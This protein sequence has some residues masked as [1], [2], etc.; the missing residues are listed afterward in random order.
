MSPSRRAVPLSAAA[1]LVL[2]L[3][4]GLLQIGRADAAPVSAAAGRLA[5][6]AGD[7][8]A[9]DGHAYGLTD[10]TGRTMDAAEIR[11]AADG[12]Y[13]AVYHTV[14][15]DGRFHAAVA[16]STDLVHWT[17]RHDFGPGTHQATLAED[18]AGGWI[19]A[20]ER[21]PR[22]HIAIRGYASLDGLLSGQADRSFDAPLTLSRCAEGTPAITAVRGDTIE[23]TGH[24]RS[25]CD[26][27]RQLRATLEDFT[28]WQAEPDPTL[29]TALRAWGSNGNIGDRSSVRLD[30][31]DLVVI[32]G[33]RLRD[34]FASWRTYIYD[35]RRGRADLLTLRTHGASTAF[36]NPAV[37]LLTSP[38]GRPALLVSAFI[39]REGAAPGEAGQ[40]VFW[41]ELGD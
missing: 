1:V 41:R 35:P 12:S 21:D 38:S 11:Q 19:L 7:A 8:R 36:A 28:T 23:L 33:Q 24:Y 10:D 20:F 40:M 13:L 29:D 18:P 26:I 15:D 9:A 32:E 37:S 14:L 34:D 6:L 27:D 4:V 25:G 39:P 22:N 17:R 3:I 31:R 2:A 30:G 5:V 16:T